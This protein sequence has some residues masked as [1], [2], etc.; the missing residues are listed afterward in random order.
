VP[1]QLSLPKVV[2]RH[3]AVKSKRLGDVSLPAE[4]SLPQGGFLREI[5]LGGE[6]GRF[7]LKA[8]RMEA[9]Q[10]ADAGAILTQ[11]SRRGAVLSNRWRTSQARWSRGDASV[12]SIRCG[13]R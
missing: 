7:R 4:S 9:G 11:A 12:D 10:M 3:S 2:V 8:A 1:F 13:G 5:V 6:I